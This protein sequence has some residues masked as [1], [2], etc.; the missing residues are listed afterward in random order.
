MGTLIHHIEFFVDRCEMHASIN[1]IPIAHMVARTEHT[2]HFAPPC[3]PFLVGEENL[4]E[5]SVRPAT[6]ED[7]SLTDWAEAKVELAV[8]TFERGG[9]VLPGGGGATVTEGDFA[10]ELAT[11]I[12]EAREADEELDVPQVFFH[13]FDS[14]GASFADELLN[15]DP[16]DDQDALTDYAL[17]IRDLFTRRDV[18]AFLVEAAPKCEVWSAAYGDPAT[19]FSDSIRDTLLSGFF[20]AGPIVAFERGDVLLVPAAGGRLWSLQRAGGLPLIQTVPDA[21]GSFLSFEI[22]AGP[23]D[24]QLRVV[25]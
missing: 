9:I 23:R 24:G 13:V 25:R 6:L 21:E 20:P 3:N 7:G 10:D 16:Y 5:V 4:V 18:D 8:R 2:E 17:H 11:R 22:M 12:E 14:E 15:A 19:A 1:G